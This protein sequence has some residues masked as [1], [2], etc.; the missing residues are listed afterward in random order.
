MAIT[1]L[2]N[3]SITSITALPSGVAS[4]VNTPK[5]IGYQNSSQ[6]L[7]KAT[8]NKIINWT[9]TVDTDS[10]FSSN[11][12]TVPTGKGGKYFIHW[13]LTFDGDSSGNTGYDLNMNLIYVNGSFTHKMQHVRKPQIPYGSFEQ[14]VITSLSAGDYVEF[15][16]HPDRGS[17]SAGNTRGLSGQTFF[18]IFKLT[19]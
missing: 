15:Y 12:F 11:K 18:E 6:S 14:T 4:D 2:N 1:R 8:D 9:T 13:N 10:A 3:N 7:T 17:G 19:E 16:F 5:V